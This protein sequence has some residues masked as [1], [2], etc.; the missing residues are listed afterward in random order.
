MA[1]SESGHSEQLSG[2]QEAARTVRMWLSRV[3]LPD[4]KKPVSTVTGTLCESSSAMV[5]DFRAVVD[6]DDTYV[7]AKRAV[8]MER[9]S[10]P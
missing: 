9:A 10:T 6:G 7:L 4:P 1:S 5:G 2:A 3:V 8:V